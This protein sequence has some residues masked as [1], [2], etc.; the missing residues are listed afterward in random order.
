MCFFFCVLSQHANFT[1]PLSYLCPTQWANQCASTLYQLEKA[2]HFSKY[3]GRM[4]V[5]KHVNDLFCQHRNPWTLYD[6]LV[7]G[8]AKL[9]DAYWWRWCTA[10]PAAQD[11]AVPLWYLFIQTAC[12]RVI[13]SVLPL[14]FILPPAWLKKSHFIVESFVKCSRKIS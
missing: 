11:M 10:T 4:Q 13:Y 3:I 8:T 7:M 14:D 2:L 12:R 5:R 9:H 6:A 1:L